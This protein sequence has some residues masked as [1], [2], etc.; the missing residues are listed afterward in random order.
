[1][2]TASL[3][4][5]VRQ[6]VLAAGLLV[7]PAF[8]QSDEMEA[9]EVLLALTRSGV[10]LEVAERPDRGAVGVLTPFG[11][12]RT[13][14]DPVEIIVERPRDTRWQAWIEV[15]AGADLSEAARSLSAQQSR[16]SH[17]AATIN[18]PKENV[19]AIRA[20][21]SKP[22]GKPPNQRRIQLIR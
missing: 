8:A 2:K 14:L 21:S 1:M 20:D 4:A 10:M 6:G 13:P 9:D 11:L 19:R 18:L 5:L 3:A 12:Y 16:R 22:N 17:H 15:D 7:S